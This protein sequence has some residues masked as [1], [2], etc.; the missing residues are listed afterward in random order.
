MSKLCA[1]TPEKSEKRTGKVLYFGATI[2]SSRAS[3]GR[4]C[5]RGNGICWCSEVLAGH[6]EDGI[7]RALLQKS[8]ARGEVLARPVLKE[9]KMTGREVLRRKGKSERVTSLDVV[10]GAVANS[11]QSRTEHY[12]RLDIR[13]KTNIRA[14]S[15]GTRGGR[16][17]F[18][19]PERKRERKRRRVCVLC[20]AVHRES[21]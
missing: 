15:R 20:R 13:G 9:L 5:G 19:E 10:Q 11:F 16:I 21:V 3:R 4:D 12:T 2:A 8:I 17:S 6:N 1:C 7:G 18:R 14:D